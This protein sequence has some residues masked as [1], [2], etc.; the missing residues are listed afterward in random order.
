[1]IGVED[2]QLSSPPYARC[3]KEQRESSPG[4]SSM[5]TQPLR[6]LQNALGQT[7][8]RVHGEFGT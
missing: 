3:I 5:E 6:K 7:L 2:M 8:S 1:M 4:R